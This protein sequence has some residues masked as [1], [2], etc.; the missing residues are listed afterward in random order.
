MNVITFI[1]PSLGRETLKN[2]INSLQNQTIENWNA[3]IIFDGIKSNLEINDKRIKVLEI[4][5]KGNGINNSGL[6]RNYG[7]KY[8]ET[9]WIAFLDDD[10]IISNDYLE[11]FY[12]ELKE[13]NNMDVL[14][15]RM[16]RGNEII[17]KLNTDNFYLCDVG[18]SFV[19]RKNIFNN[20]IQFCSD[21]V[22]DYL[23][24]NKI[25]QHNYKIIISPYVK[26]FVRETE[27]NYE[28]EKGNRV[29]INF[30]NQKISLLGYLLYFYYNEGIYI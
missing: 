5:K 25:R 4:N 2:S 18:I 19:I 7:M 29:F 13:N 23:Y 1:I 20:G 9:D 15:F 30:E 22:E 14:I 10:D 12:E 3:I 24:L 16:K 8:V 21:G 11:S 28:N 26:Y 27:N 17:P 6:V